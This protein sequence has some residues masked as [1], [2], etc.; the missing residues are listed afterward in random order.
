ML[1]ENLNLQIRD[2]NEVLKLGKVE[3]AKYSWESL[4]INLKRHNITSILLKFKKSRYLLFLFHKLKF[5]LD[6]RQLKTLYILHHF[7]L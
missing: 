3:S 5:L 1:L 7:I 4:L 2:N 6:F